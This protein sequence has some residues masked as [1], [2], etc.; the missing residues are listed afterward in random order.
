M[1][2]SKSGAPVVLGGMEI[3]H[4]VKAL[5]ALQSSPPSERSPR[6]LGLERFEKHPAGSC[7]VTWLRCSWP[8]SSIVYA[9]T[10]STM[11]ISPRYG[12]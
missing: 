8:K 7:S 5:P 11:S 1:P 4:P 2:P 9:F 3:E 10:Y 12:Q 6:P